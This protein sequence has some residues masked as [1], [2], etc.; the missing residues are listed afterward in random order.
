MSPFSVCMSVY[1]GDNAIFFKDAV[2]S[3]LEQTIVPDEIVLVV[4]GPVNEEINKVIELFSDNY[5]FFH[6]VR[7]EKNSGHAIARQAGIDAATNNLCAIMDSDDLSLPNRFEKQLKA[8][9]KHPEVTVV[10]GNITEF[11]GQPSNTIGARIVPENDN[12]I[13]K[14]LKSRCPMNLV[15]VMLK[16]DDIMK[17]GGYLDWYCEED[18]YLWLR[19]YLGGYKFYNIQDNLVNVRVGKEMYQRRGGKKYFNSEVRLQK[20]MLDK[21]IINM[22]KYLYN[23]VIRYIVQ[24]VMPNQVRGWIFQKFARQ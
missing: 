14:D 10:G 7:L 20:Y 8:F 22:P 18:Y 11:V 15:T 2:S 5:D 3:I 9:E 24:V 23:I 16:K 13:K 4:D 19:L 17:V 6:V 12:D 21:R 1:F